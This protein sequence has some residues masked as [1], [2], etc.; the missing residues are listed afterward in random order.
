MTG[1]HHPRKDK[2]ISLPFVAS[3]LA[4]A[5]VDFVY[6]RLRDQATGQILRGTTLAFPVPYRW[7]ICFGRDPSFVP[8]NA[9]TLE[10]FGVAIDGL[11]QSSIPWYDSVNLPKRTGPIPF[12]IAIGWPDSNESDLCPSNFVPYGSYSTKGIIEVRLSGGASLTASSVQYDTLHGLWVAQFDAFNRPASPCN[13]DATLTT[14][15]GVDTAPTKT[16]LVFQS[17]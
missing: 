2:Q 11:G 17:C 1:I 16:G 10:V 8:G 15:T 14:S 7:A 9:H 12:D 3:G 13:L 5:N 6:G 4:P